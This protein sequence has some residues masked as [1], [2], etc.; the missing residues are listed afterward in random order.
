[1][2]KEVTVCDADRCRTLADRACPLCE[3]DFCSE[4][5]RPMLFA[6]LC[7]R[8]R[9]EPQPG[10]A[11]FAPE[12]EKFDLHNDQH[13]E[14]GICGGCYDDLNRAQWGSGQKSEHREILQPLIKELK[15]QMI[16][17]CRAAL[18]AYKLEKSAT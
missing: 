1:M 15:P 6:Q 11:P 8:K 4:H 5:F 16:E 3:K 17:A 9:G 18:A 7:I 12:Q 2:K 10:Q 14:I 13:L